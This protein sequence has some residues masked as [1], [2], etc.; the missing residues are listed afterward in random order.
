MTVKKKRIDIHFHALGN[1]KDIEN[2]DNDIYQN[3]DDNHIWYIRLL[4]SSIQNA[5]EKLG[6][7]FNND[8][9]IATE[10]YFKLIYSLFTQ[11]KEID[12]IVLLALDAVYDFDTKDMD[13]KRTDLYIT[14]TYLSNKVDELNEQLQNDPDVE[15]KSKTFYFGASV[16]PNRDDWETELDKVLNKTNAVLMKWIP[17]AQHVDLREKAHEKFYQ[18]LSEHDMPLLCHVGPEY[19][20]PEGRRNEDL[21]NFRFLEYPLQHNVKVIAAHCAM[22]V[23]PLADKNE[24][25]EFVKFMESAN[26]GGK[27]RLWADT[28]ALS[29]Q[30]RALWIDEIVDNFPSD[31]LVHGSDYPLPFDHWPHQPWLQSKI[32]KKEYNQ[33]KKEKNPLD[34]DI[35]IKRAYDFPDSILENTAKVLGL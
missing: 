29:M 17:S 3:F 31:W 11:S 18:A 32:D 16:S 7:D 20:F 23:F 28:S 22:P 14:N 1:G 5:L 33:I 26:S 21:D 6:I 24:T 27:M 25:E 12:G 19:S 4:H 34:K 8:G 35:K 30:A 13:K 10:E 15:D 9:E 2:A